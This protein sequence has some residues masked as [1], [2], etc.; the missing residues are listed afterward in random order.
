MLFTILS[1]AWTLQ[2]WHQMCRCLQGKLSPLNFLQDLTLHSHRPNCV[3]LPLL[4]VQGTLSG[5]K[6]KAS[7]M[8]SANQ[9]SAL[10]RGSSASGASADSKVTPY[11]M[12]HQE[13]KFLALQT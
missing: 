4:V 6:R 10:S 13:V 8:S 5:L 3:D 12:Y 1:P 9:G 7:L 2:D 11:S